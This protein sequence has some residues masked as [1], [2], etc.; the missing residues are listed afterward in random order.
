MKLKFPMAIS[1]KG[2]TARIYRASQTQNGQRYEGYSVVY[3][4][5][6]KKKRLWRTAPQEA[7]AEAESACDKIANGEQQVLE[8]TNADRQIYLRAKDWLK[9][10]GIELDIAARDHAALVKELPPGVTAKDLLDCY[11]RRSGM[12]LEKRTVRQAVDEL[13]VAKRGAN[14][15]KVYLSDLESRL[16]RF[17]N[18]FQMNIADVTGKMI[19]SWLDAMDLSGRTK[20]NYLASVQTLF[21]FAI[22]RKYLPKDALDEIEAVERPKEDA[23][24]VEIFTPDEIREILSV[25]RPEIVPCLAIGA[26]AGLRSF[27]I[28]RLDWS[29]IN[30][31]EGYIEIKA[32]KAKTAARRTVPITDNL[33]KWLAPKRKESGPV[34]NFFW[35]WH[36]IPAIVNRVNKRREANARKAGIDPATVKK[37]AWKHNGLRH[38]FCSYR[39]AAIKNTA[40]VA[41]EAG[42]S[43]QM[44]FQHYRQVV[45]ESEAGKWFSIVPSGKPTIPKA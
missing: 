22:R 24:D 45:T 12:A 38:S 44:I 16:G 20:Q 21:R 32:A 28:T 29:D 2:V 1:R 14:V 35:W 41:L 40:Q 27:E 23:A 26:F 30:L 33:A 19:Q 39:L 13:A 43:P 7:I 11:R 42:N 6:G 37:F 36:L 31:N 10:T 34:V 15:S 8:L 5:L 9:G 25:A 17:A 4:L 18:D 3:F